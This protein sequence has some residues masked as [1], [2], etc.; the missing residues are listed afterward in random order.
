MLNGKQLMLNDFANYAPPNASLWQGRKDSLPEERFFQQV[1]LQDLRKQRLSSPTKAVFIGFCSDE[2]IRRNLGRTGAKSG[3]QALR[4]QLGKLPYQGK[5]LFLDAGDIVCVDEQLE[6][7]QHQLAAVISHFHQQQ[8]KTVVFGGGHEVAWGHFQGLQ[9]HYSK[10]GIIN[11]DAHFDLRPLPENQK[12]N[13]GTPF[14]QM[15]EFCKQQNRPFDY[16]CLGIQPHANTKSLFR[17]AKEY[18]VS[19][20]SA[21]QIN[22]LDLSSQFNFLEQF[23]KN[24]DAIYLTICLDVLA[25]SCAPG[26]S[27]PQPIGLQPWQLIPLLQYVMRTGKVVSFDIAE[28]SPPLDQ[29]QQTARL[30]AML[31]A[32]LLEI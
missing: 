7:A 18:K 29:H 1:L 28:L 6:T 4:E 12:G 5:E 30:A 15:A 26:V 11:F 23:I 9:A 24:Q 10:L 3:P 13:S 31:V 21:E 19:T 17:A 25:E 27:A 14:L 32:E 20:L 2:G 16:C 8:Q 22:R